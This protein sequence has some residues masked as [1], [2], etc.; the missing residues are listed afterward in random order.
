MSLTPPELPGNND[1]LVPGQDGDS[2]FDP[3]TSSETS[4]EERRKRRR[5][6]LL[7]LC[8]A[9]FALEVGLFLVM[10]PWADSWSFNSLQSYSPL[11]EDIWEEPAFKGALVGIGLLNVYVAVAQF[12]QVLRNQ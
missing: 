2:R 12:L 9:I 6:R 5:R 8:F 1:G 4:K 3:S 11:I 7:R 10:F